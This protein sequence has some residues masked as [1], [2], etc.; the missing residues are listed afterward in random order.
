MQFLYT[1]KCVVSLPRTMI[2]RLK[3]IYFG[4]PNLIR[5]IGSFL[6]EDLWYDRFYKELKDSD[7]L[8]NKKIEDIQNDRLK[9]IIKHCY[10]NVPYYRETFD[11]L[12]LK[13]K[14][15]TNTD[16][17]KK[18][19]VISR[20]DINLNRERML[21]KNIPARNLIAAYTSGTTGSPMKL[22]FTKKEM[23]FDGAR[24]D[25]HFEIAGVDHKKGHFLTGINLEGSRWR[26]EPQHKVMHLNPSFF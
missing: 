9:K 4:S 8:D 16:D 21:A 20:G 15:I 17:L 6:Y 22:F 24:I 14:D 1:L 13:S 26:Y 11:K 5:D 25:K 10:E 19:P 12:N 2:N 23:I 7:Y 18:L 3:K